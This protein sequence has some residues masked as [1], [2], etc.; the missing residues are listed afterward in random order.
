MT[1]KLIVDADAC[2]KLGGS[3]KYHFLHQLVPLLT[4]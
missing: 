3:E 4:K 2:I 1:D